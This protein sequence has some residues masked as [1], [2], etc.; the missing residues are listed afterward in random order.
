MIYYI[1]LYDVILCDIMLCYK[2]INML[3][4]YIEI[5]KSS[6]IWY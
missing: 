2:K 3:I 5:K 1:I 4:E 6:N